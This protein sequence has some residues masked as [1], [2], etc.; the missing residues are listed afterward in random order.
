MGDDQALAERL[1]QEWTD[2]APNTY[3]DRSAWPEWQQHREW[4]ARQITAALAQARREQREA[5]VAFL[6]HLSTWD[7]QSS[8]AG[9]AIRDARSPIIGCAYALRDCAPC[10]PPSS[11]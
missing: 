6:L 8:A 1:A 2:Q 5:D 9:R 7:G 3:G 4:L 11:P 10:T